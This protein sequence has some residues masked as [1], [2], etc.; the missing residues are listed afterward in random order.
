MIAAMPVVGGYTLLLLK[1]PGDRKVSNVG[2]Y[3][4]NE[5]VLTFLPVVVFSVV[6]GVLREQKH[7]T[8]L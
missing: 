7:F 1:E 8:V 6:P 5:R 2:Q 3:E 4:S